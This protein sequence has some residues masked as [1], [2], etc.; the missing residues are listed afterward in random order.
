MNRAGAAVLVGVR[1]RV[2]YQVAGESSGCV[3]RAKIITEGADQRVGAYPRLLLRVRLR[4]TQRSAL[5]WLARLS[6][7]S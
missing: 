4:R 7:E 2:S 3:V 5:G 6:E 1:L